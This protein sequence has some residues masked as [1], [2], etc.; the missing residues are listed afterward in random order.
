MGPI[1]EFILVT[2]VSFLNFLDKSLQ[3]F[4]IKLLRMDKES[5]M[6]RLTPELREEAKSK[7]IALPFDLF[8]QGMEHDRMMD[9]WR[10][11][12]TNRQ[13]K[14]ILQIRIGI[15]KALQMNPDIEKVIVFIN[16][17]I[18]PVDSNQALPIFG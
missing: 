16:C 2:I 12:E 9:F 1:L 14:Q 6:K 3:T 11:F 10:R 18:I 17:S 8:L 4:G 7:D 5:M 15:K 13:L